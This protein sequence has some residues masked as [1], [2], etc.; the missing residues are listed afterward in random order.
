MTSKTIG[1]SV[2]A[3]HKLPEKGF[4]TSNEKYK[5]YS[6]VFGGFLYML[7]STSLNRD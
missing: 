3:R 2:L 7:V 4:E 1:L 5:A 6:T